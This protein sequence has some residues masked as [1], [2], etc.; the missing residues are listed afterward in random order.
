MTTQFDFRGIVLGRQFEDALV[1][2]PNFAYASQV[3]DPYS[4]EVRN[5]AFIAYKPI[6][7]SEQ[8]G[9]RLAAL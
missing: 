6:Q 9:D 2:W 7:C 3:K 5:E 8:L 4:I 1:D